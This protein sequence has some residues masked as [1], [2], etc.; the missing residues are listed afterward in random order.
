MLGLTMSVKM[1][2]AMTNLRHN[3]RTL[4]EEE[5]QHP[6]HK[7]II[8]EKTKDNLIIKQSTLKDAY[9]EVFGEAVEEYNA[10]QKRK[11]RKIDDYYLHVY[12]SKT[13]DLQREMIIGLGNVD[14]WE[15]LGYEKKKE[16]GQLLKEVVED[17]IKDKEG[18]IHVYNA[19]VHLDEAGAPHAHINFIPLA[20]GYR[21]G[22]STQPSWTKSL[23][24][25]GYQGKGRKPFMAFRETEV[26]RIE[27]IAKKYGIERKLG[28]TNELPDV[29]TYK[30]VKELEK[31]AKAKEAE[32]EELEQDFSKKDR[33]LKSRAF[34]QAKALSDFNERLENKVKKKEGELEQLESE[35]AEKQARSQK[36]G[37]TAH[38]ARQEALEAKQAK[39][40]AQNETQELRSEVERL[41]SEKKT[42]QEEAEK[43]KAQVEAKEQALAEK[44]KVISEKDSYISRQ[45]AQLEHNARLLDEQT[46]N[47]DQQTNFI[48]RRMRALQGIEKASR[49]TYDEK[50]VFKTL[51]KVTMD[52]S[53]YE[54]LKKKAG[55][56]D[57]LKDFA[58][59]I[60]STIQETS[61]YKALEAKMTAEINKWKK[62]YQSLKAKVTE[63]EDKVDSQNDE[64]FEL[65][66]ERDNLREELKEEQELR[67]KLDKYLKP[68]EKEELAAKIER[69]EQREQEAIRQKKQGYWR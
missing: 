17:F 57:S 40:Q 6:D 22:L 3:N 13:L 55:F 54:N 24:Q 19:V 28:E 16:A 23:A 49:V 10:K 52:Q 33:E 47:Y 69:R 32:I 68:R 7:H 50:G 5:Y 45:Q 53:H 65:Y 43:L 15:K 25:M 60:V 34:E 42:V 29:K 12:H 1:E 35:L 11:D 56:F 51:G 38:Q 64:L 20:H 39:E 31:Q 59:D 4:T 36:A 67:E 26:S 66:T 27:K 63:L 2:K 41:K 46:K 14:D 44:D 9:E 30:K 62:A 61:V 58:T 8:R 18:H 37:A 21:N 48:E